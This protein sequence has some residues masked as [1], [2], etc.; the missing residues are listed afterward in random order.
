[1]KYSEIIKEI[2]SFMGYSKLNFLCK[3]F[4]ELGVKYEG[5]ICEDESDFVEIFV[6][7]QITD[8]MTYYYLLNYTN[9]CNLEK[10]DENMFSFFNKTINDNFFN[11]L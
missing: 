2:N 6:S 3:L 4:I 1:M 10:N 7:E 8:A 11:I 5:G 9:F